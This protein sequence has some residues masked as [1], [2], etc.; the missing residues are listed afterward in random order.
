[1][2]GPRSCPPVTGDAGPAAPSR[3]AVTD[4]DGPVVVVRSSGPAGTQAVAA[5]LAERLRAGDAVLL[6]GDLGAGKT[7][8]TQGLARGLGVADV[9]TSPTFTLVRDYPTTAGF[10]LLHADVYRLE[11]LQEI[12]DLGLP[13][14]LEEG[15]CA[16]IEWGERAALA[17]APDYLSVVLAYGEGDRERSLTLRPVGANW[18]ARFAGLAEALAAGRDGSLVEGRPDS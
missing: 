18:T 15:A 3:G 2:S 13:E 17:L 16:V 14:Q 12:L 1:M 6:G 7:T 5:V 4:D 11:Q 8:F 10:R 9:V